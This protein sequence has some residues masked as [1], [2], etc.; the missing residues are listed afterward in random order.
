MALVRPLNIADRI[1]PIEHIQ[2]IGL[3]DEMD[4]YVVGFSNP[5][6]K[7]QAVYKWDLLI[8]IKQKKVIGS[9]GAPLTKASLSY[10]DKKLA[11]QLVTRLMQQTFYE[12]DL[13]RIFG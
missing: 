2:S 12:K 10:L 4:S 8:D 1:Y 7:N 3:F 9:S 6:I 11:L 5:M 13:A